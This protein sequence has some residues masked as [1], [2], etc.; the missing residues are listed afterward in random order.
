MNGIRPVKRWALIVGG[1]DLTWSFSRLIAPVVTT[2]AIILR[3]NKIQ[4]GDI[5]I[6]A[7]P[8][9]PGK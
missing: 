9:P 1:D 5:P 3:S 7:N 4:R 8:G 2:T 6:S